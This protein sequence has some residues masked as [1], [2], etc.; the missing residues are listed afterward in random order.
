MKQQFVGKLWLDVLSK[1]DLLEEEFDAVDEQAAPRRH[2]LGISQANP[3]TASVR[4]G[5]EV[6]LTA[7]EQASATSWGGWQ[8]A[9][10]EEG[11]GGGGGVE[12]TTAEQ[13]AAALPH[14]LRVSSVTSV[15]LDTLKVRGFGLD[16]GLGTLHLQGLG[17]DLGLA[18]STCGF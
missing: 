11:S 6:S 16:V 7:E 10:W 18:R 1:A 4:K 15:G 9:S 13:M 17:L 14:A 5:T 8:A 2:T 12:V 3:D